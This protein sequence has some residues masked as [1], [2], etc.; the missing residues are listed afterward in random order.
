MKRNG[1]N[2]LSS[3][4]LESQTLRSEMTRVDQKVKRGCIPRKNIQLVSFKGN[5][6]QKVSETWGDRDTTQK[7]QGNQC[8]L[9][10]PPKLS[11]P[12]QEY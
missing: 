6:D 4:G 1:G 10:K 8:I 11:P 9:G 2:S 7:A 3:Q 5:L 12:S